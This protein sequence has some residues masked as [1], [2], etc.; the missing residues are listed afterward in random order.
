MFFNPDCDH[1]QN[2][3][4][5]L[6]AYKEELKDIPILMISAAPYSEIKDFYETFNLH[7]LTN[8]V[9]GH[10]ENFKLGSIYKLRTYPSI[11]VYDNKGTLAK[12]FVGNIGIPA[13]LDALK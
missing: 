13:I 9:V 4:K 10:D 5:E 3:T 11:F 8:I 1:C 7:A 2:E 6:M 12:A